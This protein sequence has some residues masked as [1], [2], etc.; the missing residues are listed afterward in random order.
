MDIN[1]KALVMAG[2]VGAEKTFLVTGD[3][4]REKIL[5]LSGGEGFD[6]VMD[7][8]GKPHVQLLGLNLLKVAGKFVAVGYSPTDAFQINSMRLVSR[9]LEVYGSRSCGRNDLK[10][11]IE[12]VSSGK[13]KPVVAQFHR[14]ADANAALR[15]LDQGDLVGRSVLIP[16]KD[17]SS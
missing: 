7:F 4:P 11:T 2:E 5:E 10:E 13:V 16:G 6:A 14:L 9:E 17:A 8:V 15:K 1:E 3:D 12:L